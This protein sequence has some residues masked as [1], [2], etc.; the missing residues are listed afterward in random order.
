MLGWCTQ[1]LH[2]GVECHRHHCGIA[3]EGVVDIYTH[4]D[5]AHNI[6]GPIIHDQPML[7]EV[8]GE[9][10]YY[11]EVIAVI[12]AETKEAIKEAKS[13]V[14]LDITPTTQFCRL[15]MPRLQNVLLV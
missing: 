2:P 3:G 12:A 8:G 5:L 4:A 6:W 13:A 1:R 10:Q 14:Q 7:V 15:M 11:G 9:I